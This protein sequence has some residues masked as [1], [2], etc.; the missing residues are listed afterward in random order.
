MGIQGFF[1]KNSINRFEGEVG[2]EN[3]EKILRH[4]DYAGDD[5]K[6]GSP[7]EKFLADNPG[8]IERLVEFIEENF[9][10]KFDGDEFEVESEEDDEPEEPQDTE[11]D[12]SNILQ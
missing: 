7:V 3:L 8:A 11:Q 6:H 4:I 10:D 1:D 5:F 12:F 9:Y 2:I